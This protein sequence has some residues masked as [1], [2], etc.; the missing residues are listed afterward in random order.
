MQEFDREND[1][2][3]SKY[4]DKLMHHNNHVGMYVYNRLSIEIENGEITEVYEL[5]LPEKNFKIKGQI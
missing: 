5:T 3:K 4:V 1:L 2:L